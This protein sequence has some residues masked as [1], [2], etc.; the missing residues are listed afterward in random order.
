[1]VNIPSEDVRVGEILHLVENDY[2][3]CDAIV[4]STSHASGY[5]YLMTANLDGETSL[6]TKFSAKSTARLKTKDDL[7]DLMAGIECENPNPKIES[8]LGRLF[9]FSGDCER[10][11]PC[12]LSAENLINSGTQI[13]NVEEVFC[14]C[15]YAGQETK[16]ALN[17]QITKNKFSSIEK[18]LNSYIFFFLFVL[19]IE[20][21][22][23]TIFSMS[24]GVIWKRE[25][26]EVNYYLNAIK[27]NKYLRL[28]GPM[29]E[30]EDKEDYEWHWY[31]FQTPIDAGFEDGLKMFLTWMVLFNYIIPIS[32]YVSLELQKVVLSMQF[33]WDQELYDPERD[34]QAV[35]RTSD[36]SEELGLVTHLF[37]DKTGTLTQNIMVFRK[38]C[39]QEVVHEIQSLMRQ[40]YNELIMAMVLCHSVDVVDNHFVASSPDEK[41]ILEALSGSGFV[42]LGTDDLTK[43]MKVKVRGKGIYKYKRMA[44]LPF[45]SER[46]CM[47]IIVREE[48]VID[49]EEEPKIHVLVK[50]AES[51]ILP[52][53]VH[54]PVESTEQIVNSMASEGLR[55]L[56]YGHR[57]ID[58][59]TYANFVNELEVARRS[60]VNRATF[61]RDAYRTIER[62]LHLL[63]AIGIEDKLQEDVAETIHKLTQAGIITWMLT[64]DK[65]ETAMNLA[66][67]SGLLKQRQKI[68]DLCEVQ[69]WKSL[70]ALLRELY[71]TYKEHAR[72]TDRSLVIDGKAVTAVMSRESMK[73]RL[74]VITSM[75]Q[76]VIACRLSPVQ[77]SQ[78]VRLMKEWGNQT[79][80]IGDGGNDISMIQEA[81][82]GFGIIGYEGKA[83]SEAADFAFTKF[84]HLQRVLL[85]HG[86]W[87]YTRLAFLVQYSFYK[88]VACF[89]CQNLFAFLSNFSA[90][91]L[92]DSNFL[93]LYNTL[94][95]AV[96]VMIYGIAEQKFSSQTLVHNPRF[97]TMNRFGTRMSILF[98]WCLFG[99]WHTVAIF[100][101]WLLFLNNDTTCNCGSDMDL[102][103]WGA[104]IGGTCVTVVSLKILVEAKH[105]NL[106]LVVSVFCSIGCY[107][108]LTLLYEQFYN[109]SS[110]LNN[111][112]TFRS[113]IKSLSGECGAAIVGLNVLII[114][115]A[116]LPD[117][118]YSIYRSVTV[119]GL[120]PVWKGR[121]VAPGNEYS[122][123]AAQ[124]KSGLESDAVELC[125]VRS[126]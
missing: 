84:K 117:Y 70:F 9:L 27:T 2:V 116:L 61:M 75:C 72:L 45:D 79:A 87:Y 99:V 96:P 52:V 122:I 59:E 55:T 14:V 118:L 22:L 38:F 65:K 104:Q 17:S 11:E 101:G 40:D 115:I 95:T 20:L 76:T 25:F 35:C 44:E 3:P 119:F 112:N 16:I 34:I 32:L 107:V 62:E 124:N 26:P 8:F 81:H 18:M 126:K 102:A 7:R 113:Y 68:I 53:C 50:G 29:P 4:L 100:F 111:Q 57:I 60:I 39:Y 110:V 74:A 108:A 21:V 82:V 78:L 85:V 125:E 80:A 63:G 43:I 77:K 56:V 24:Y 83:A 98:Q 37:A 67:A 94:F 23:Y 90:Q 41:A 97:Y 13:K 47:S 123:Q 12:P 33:S 92:F 66:S 6:K 36:I 48:S 42:F 46:K 93:F 1:M 58:Q 121:K 10:F 30:T 51:T 5:C 15:V 120:K 86:H 114:V 71:T 73:R 89:T 91:S 64:G 31:L 103:S 28:L 19:L 54:G 49:E 105:W 106:P 88:N 69:D 109:D